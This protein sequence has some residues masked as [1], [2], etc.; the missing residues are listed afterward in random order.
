VFWH[1]VEERLRAL[2]GVT[3]VTLIDG[4][5]PSRP[6]MAN[7]L[8]LPK[9]TKKPDDPVWNVDYWQVLGEDG[10]ATLGARIIKGRDFTRSDSGDAPPVALVNEAFANK[11]FPGEDPIGKL[12]NITPWGKN[13]DDHHIETVVGLVA[14]IKQAGIDKPAGSEVF[15][16]LYQ[17]KGLW[18]EPESSSAMRVI[19]RTAGDPN[20]MIPSAQRAIADLDPSLPLFQVRSMDDVLWE[21]VAR[22]RFLTFLMSCFAGLALLL[23][24]VGIYG[25]MAHTVA[26]RTHEIGLRVALG[27][28][29]AHVRS[30][31]L[32][33][34]GAL[35][36]VGVMVGLGTAV[37]LQLA[38]DAS[39]KGLFYGERLVQ[40]L[41]LAGVAVAVTVTALVAT[42]LPARR[43]TK[44]E[45]TVALRSE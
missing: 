9:R 35:V 14:D 41:L 31:I 36:A 4:M 38:L 15:V 8:G 32:R 30:M 11:F 16:P 13:E 17:Y 22:P 2:P 29:P 33:Q 7:D 23:A 5:P 12:V 27:A 45:P 20:A 37:G 18:D 26:Q 44:V 25:V 21:A 3:S 6:I 10:I 34:A 1:R 39:L 40:P 24:A 43:A 28:Q 42:W 19:L